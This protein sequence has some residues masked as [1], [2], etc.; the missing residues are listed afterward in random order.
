MAA[1]EGQHVISGLYGS[2]WKGSQLLA[3]V[4]SVDAPIDIGRIA[5]PQV[6]TRSEGRKR[7]RETREGT[8]TVHKYDS[9]W[10][11]FVWE[12]YL[13]VSDDTIRERRNSGAV[14]DPSFELVLKMDDPEA[15]GVERFA[16]YG[17]NL[18]R[19][20]LGFNIGDEITQR[21]Y[22]ITW[23]TERPLTAFRKVANQ[24]GQPVASYAYGAP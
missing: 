7:G 6:G 3:E 2:A 8:M 13:S 17:V 23:E 20:P 10:E 14:V 4:I 16:L 19:L 15:V 5:V 18:W 12:N 1:N 24:Q 22:P 9:T 21:E 11:L